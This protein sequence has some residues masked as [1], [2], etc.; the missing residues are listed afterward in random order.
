MTVRLQDLARCFQGVAPAIICT[1]ARDGTPNV[2][3]L[4]QVYLVDAGHVALSRQFF[5]KTTKNIDENPLAC[6]QIYDPLTLDSYRLR[7]RYRRS[8]TTGLLFDTMALRIQM[9]A[10]HTGMAGIFRLISAD[11]YAVDAV[12]EIEGF[13]TPPDDDADADAPVEPLTGPLNELRSLQLV[14][15]RLRQATDLLTTWRKERRTDFC[16]R[17]LRLDPSLGLPALRDDLESRL[18]LLRKRLAEKCPDVRLVPRRR[19]VFGLEIACGVELIERET[20]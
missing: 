13:L 11:V 3:Y 20:A 6:V 8:E 17:E 9:I 18:M 10:S 4:S 19:G 16:N 12:E 2:T 1:C 7:L 5:N 14:S 15:D